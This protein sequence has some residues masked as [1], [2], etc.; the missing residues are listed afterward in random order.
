MK[1]GTKGLLDHYE[2]SFDEELDFAE[3]MAMAQTALFL[4][5]L[6]EET[7]IS[8][9]ELAERI[10]VSESRISQILDADSNPTVRTMARIA[11]ALDH[12]VRIEF[13]AQ[14]EVDK[15]QRWPTLPNSV[16]SSESVSVADDFVEAVNDN[17]HKVAA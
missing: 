7:G 10:G 17:N 13:T 16:W 8:Q 6:L 5:A 11:R 3:E 9:R 2:R 15:A 4:A 1:K 12:H 14:L